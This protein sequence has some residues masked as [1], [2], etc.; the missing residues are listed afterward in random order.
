MK[1]I[2]DNRTKFILK[3]RIREVKRKLNSLEKDI[4]TLE[5]T[6]AKAGEEVV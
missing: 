2:I 3:V 6:L 5:D 1:K 4:Q